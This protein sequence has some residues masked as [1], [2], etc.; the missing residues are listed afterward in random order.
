MRSHSFDL[1]IISEIQN[2]NYKTFYRWVRDEF[3]EISSP[4]VQQELHGHDTPSSSGSGKPYMVEVP[5]FRPECVGESMAIDEKS[6]G[7]E[8]YTVFTNSKTG[9][10]ALMCSSL[11]ASNIC[12]IMSRF[13][14][15]VL[16]R[17]KSVTRDFSATYEA[18]AT[19]MLPSAMQTVDKFHTVK[20]LMSDLQSFRIELKNKELKRY[21]K[22]RAAHKKAYLEDQRLPRS[23]QTIRKVYHPQTLQNGET[24]AE[25][26]NRSK[27]LLYK[28]PDD[29]TFRQAQRAKLLFETFPELHLPYQQAVTFRNWYQGQINDLR[30]FKECRLKEWIDDVMATKKSPL[31][32]F[33]DTIESN[34]DYVLNYFV[35]HNTNAIAESTNA[36]IQIAAIKN[37]GARDIDFFFFRL[38]HFL[39][40]VTSF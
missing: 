18:V 29:W 19:R 20:E 38:A 33:A 30:D 15:T 13:G 11:E 26:L 25:L 34:W 8:V 5:I 21:K 27:Y 9:N 2:I 12:L 22:E 4:K 39:N 16:G 32:A 28:R 14:E 36:K 37:R 10:I 35:G 1:K 31:S 6:V 40:P 3:C 23:K 7:N 24:T 17:V